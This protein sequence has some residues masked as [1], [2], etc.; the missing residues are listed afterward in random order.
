MLIAV[1]RIE[2]SKSYLSEIAV[3]QS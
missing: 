2:D 3:E 1:E